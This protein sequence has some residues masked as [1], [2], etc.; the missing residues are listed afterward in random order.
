MSTYEDKYGASSATQATI[1][2]FEK[3]HG[4][5]TM[6]RVTNLLLIALYT[7]AM[8]LHV[9]CLSVMAAKRNELVDK[10]RDNPYYKGLNVEESC[11]LFIDYDGLDSYGWAQIKWVNNKCHIVI[12]GSAALGGCALL[13]II[14]LAMKT[15]LFRK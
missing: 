6:S 11:L 8:V 14:L 10:F 9:V 7:A 13:M 2:P 15:L 4:V 1:L 5:I 3:R 12:Y